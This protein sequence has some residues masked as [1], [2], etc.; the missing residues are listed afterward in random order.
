MR[1]DGRLPDLLID[2]LPDSLPDSL[3]DSCACPQGIEPVQAD[4]T[5]WVFSCGDESCDDVCALV[6]APCNELGMQAVN[7]Q[8]KGIYVLGLV[9]QYPTSI[10]GEEYADAPVVDYYS[11][12]RSEFYWVRSVLPTTAVEFSTETSLT[13]PDAPTHLRRTEPA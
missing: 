12:F 5:A 8:A 10:Y 13:N 3:T 2:S 4:G 6:N 11:P 7:T 9:D 1:D